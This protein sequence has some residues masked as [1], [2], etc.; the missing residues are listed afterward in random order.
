MG[1]MAPWDILLLDEVTVDLDVLVRGD[2]ID[3]LIEES[4]T[5]K[6]TI[7]YCQSRSLQPP[8]SSLSLT[9]LSVFPHRHPHLRRESQSLPCLIYVRTD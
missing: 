6:A 8:L 3:F 5:R 7:V 2:L 9:P 1:L 4:K